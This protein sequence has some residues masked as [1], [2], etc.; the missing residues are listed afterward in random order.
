MAPYAH[1]A[2]DLAAVLSSTDTTKRNASLLA[3]LAAAKSQPLPPMFVEAEDQRPVLRLDAASTTSSVIPVVDMSRLRSPDPAARAALVTDVATACERFG[4]FQVVNHGVDEALIERCETEAHKMFELPLEV[5]E[6]VHRPPQTSF[7]YGANTWVNQAVMHWAESFHMQLHPQSN[8]REF[9]GKLFAESD[10]TKFRYPP[11]LC[12]RPPNSQ[13]P[14]PVSE[15]TISV[16]CY[17]D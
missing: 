4:F 16:P 12:S 3:A 11:S 14:F 15:S 7:G 17:S 13:L 2:A 10:P 6:R 1:N 8:I 5:K 9:S